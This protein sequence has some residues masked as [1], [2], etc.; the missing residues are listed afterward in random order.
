MCS[1]TQQS[2]AVEMEAT[3][4][5]LFVLLAFRVAS[6]N[7]NQPPAVRGCV[8][9]DTHAIDSCCNLGY[10]YS[11]FGEVFFQPNVYTIKNFCGNCLSVHKGYCD[12]I[13]DG[14]GWLV[15]QRRKDGS[16]DFDRDWVDYED[17]F[18]S[19][20]GEFWY[21]LSAIHCLTSRGQWELRIDYTFT[22]GTKGYVSYSNFRVGPA[23]DQYRLTISGFDGV[24]T[25]LFYTITSNAY[26]SLNGWRFTTRDKDNDRWSN[27]CA[28]HLNY[29]GGGWWYNHCGVLYLNGQYNRSW[30][31]QLNGHSH[32]LPFIEIK[33]RL[34]NCTI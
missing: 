11:T 24:T 18:G 2:L 34:K 22:N 27:N 19:L 16:V 33:I 9:D 13:T 25:D 3:Y 26:H 6:S 10:R 17:G 12:T 30:N 4:I 14:G 23:T 5:L 8:V 28:V 31:I 1:C 21:G 29:G 15:V 7:N 20:T 32:I